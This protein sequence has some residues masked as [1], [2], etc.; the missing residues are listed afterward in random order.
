[1]TKVGS[2]RGYEGV[3]YVIEEGTSEIGH[4]SGYN[5]YFRSLITGTK[6]PWRYLREE[7]VVDGDGHVNAFKAILKEALT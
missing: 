4:Q 2:Q 7:A 3:Y 6:G 1:M 5:Y